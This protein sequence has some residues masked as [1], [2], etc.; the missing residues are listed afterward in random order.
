[1]NEAN[2]KLEKEIEYL[3]ME[4]EQLSRMLR[5][6]SCNMVRGTALD[7]RNEFFWN[8]LAAPNDADDLSKIISIFTFFI[9]TYTNAELEA[10][11]LR[12]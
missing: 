2:C 9:R 12:R 1:M 3:Q 11:I 8:I 4:K 6:H 5:E 7:P 10:N